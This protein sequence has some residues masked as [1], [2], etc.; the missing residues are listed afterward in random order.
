MSK[1][2]PP[3]STETGKRFCGSCGA[4]NPAANSFCA[5]CGKP[6]GDAVQA[7]PTVQ[8]A[9]VQGR[10]R[11]DLSPRQRV[12]CLVCLS[13]AGWLLFTTMQKT[14]P[15]PAAS[16]PASSI[17]DLHAAVKLRDGQFSIT[18][19]DSFDWMN[20]KLKINSG[21]FQ[22][23]YVLTVPRLEAGATYTVGSMQFAKGDGTRFNPFTVKPQGFFIWCDTPKGNGSWSGGMD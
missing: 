12:F 15:H 9:P 4:E 18:N 1:I 3:A 22:D 14:A 23:G 19:Q 7:R 20:V 13:V 17:L 2:V 16:K 6:L 5:G 11:S 21:L 10:K 8:A